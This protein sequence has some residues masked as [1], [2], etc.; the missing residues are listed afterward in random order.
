MGCPGYANPISLRVGEKTQLSARF[1]SDNAGVTY[2]PTILV[3]LN[4]S[5]LTATYYQY[6]VPVAVR[7]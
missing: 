3:T 4:Y 5:G 7:K 6:S 2:R 1:R